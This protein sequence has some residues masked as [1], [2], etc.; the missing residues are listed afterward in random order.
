MLARTLNLLFLGSAG[1]G[2]GGVSG[3]CL[4]LF[5]PVSCSCMLRR[6]VGDEMFGCG[7]VVAKVWLSRCG[8]GCVKVDVW[9]WR[10]GRGAM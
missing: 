9:K 8:D 4:V 6:R 10:C 2:S 3:D 1:G 7:G 5:P